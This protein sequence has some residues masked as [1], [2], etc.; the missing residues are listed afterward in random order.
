MHSYAQMTRRWR[1]HVSWL[2]Q[3]SAC[4][5]ARSRAQ[6]HLRPLSRRRAPL[7]PRA[8]G[9]GPLVRT[10]RT[11]R[12]STRASCSFNRL[13]RAAVRSTTGRTGG[14]RVASTR[15]IL[16]SAGLRTIS[17]APTAATA[18]MCNTCRCRRSGIS[19]WPQRVRRRS[20]LWRRTP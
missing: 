8:T 6:L 20:Y 4:R 11:R 1:A 12:V 9:A 16:A 18:T 14:A 10:W 2:V 15:S 17:H 19:T 5:A 7:A 13:A 3:H